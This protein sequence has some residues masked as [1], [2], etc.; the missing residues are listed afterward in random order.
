MFKRIGFPTVMHDAAGRGGAGTMNP[1]DMNL[2]ARRAVINQAV[3]MTQQIFT[4]TNLNVTPNTAPLVLNIP[5]RQ[6]GL[7]KRLIV[8]VAATIQAN[9]QTLS[10]C[11]FGP[12]QMFSQVVLTDLS[13]Q[14]RINTAGWHLHGVA[15]AKRRGV[16]GAAYTTDTPTGFGSNYP[17]VMAAPATITTNPVT[18]N[19]FCEFEIPLSY[20]DQDLRGAIYMNVTNATAFLQLTVNPNFFV[21]SGADKTFGVYQSNSATLGL[22]NSFQV[23]VYQ[24]YLDQLPLSQN[25]GP[26]LPLLDL[27]TAYLLNTTPISGLVANQDVPIPYA[28]FR[29][30]MSTFVIFDNAGTLNSGSDVAYWALQSANFTNIW[31]YDPQIT[32]FL[33]RAVFGDDP[34]AGV[35]YMDH[36]QKP[37]STIQ[38]GNMSLV[39]NASSVTAGASLSMGYEQL[40]LI[41]MITQ[42]GALFGT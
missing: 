19:V 17:S 25:G 18:N 32:A 35:Y 22:I 20:T 2:L 7:V 4:Q 33:G 10:L 5:I 40:A 21:A 15:S 1:V 30:F 34:P 39:L 16:Y 3:D 13:N 8:R 28:N 23:T 38:Y 6:V 37:I 41:N 42:A 24:N 27:S 26:V 14:T 36:R 9:G 29:D 11:P 31:K 12:T